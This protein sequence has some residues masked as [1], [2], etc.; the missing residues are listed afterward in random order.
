MPLSTLCFRGLG[1]E[2]MV[3][4]F[5]ETSNF[6]QEEC[7]ALLCFM[8]THTGIKC[9][10]ET[11]MWVNY[12]WVSVTLQEKAFPFCMFVDEETEASL[13]TMEDNSCSQYALPYTSARCNGKI[14]RFQGLST[15]FICFFFLSMYFKMLSLAAWHVHCFLK[16]ICQWFLCK[17]RW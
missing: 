12:Q 1:E 14:R 15:Y 2:C 8:L 6:I 4:S 5:F 11:M 9:P 16:T 3:E 10:Q 7:F 17:D 13:R